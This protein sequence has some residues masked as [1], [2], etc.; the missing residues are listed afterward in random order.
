MAQ[1]DCVITALHACL[2]LPNIKVSSNSRPLGAQLHCCIQ[3]VTM[4]SHDY[5]SGY[6]VTIVVYFYSFAHI[7][8]KCITTYFMQWRKHGEVGAIGQ[9]AVAPAGEEC[10]PGADLA[11]LPQFM[12]TDRLSRT[13]T[14]AAGPRG[15]ATHNAVQVREQLVC[16][17]R[18]Q[19]VFS[20]LWLF[21]TVAK[22]L[23]RLWANW[24][25]RR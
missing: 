8:F 9:D 23:I 19:S 25:P 14:A 22:L 18:V 6:A 5:D 4:G 20:G 13:V 11:G 15:S 2:Y 7:E 17:L 10:S 12:A 24:S 21:S 16:I 1:H 3:D